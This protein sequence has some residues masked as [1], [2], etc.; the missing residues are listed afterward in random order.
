MF[1]TG[2]DEKRLDMVM[3]KEFNLS[4]VKSVIMARGR[5]SFGGP[6]CVSSYCYHPT[7]RRQVEGEEAFSDRFRPVSFP[8][9][10]F[11]KAVA[12]SR[13]SIVLLSIQF[14]RHNV[15]YLGL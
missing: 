3:R 7:F 8:L 2:V 11:W 6:S 14:L 1:S 15:L 13:A 12:G 10:S 9:G 4:R 5:S